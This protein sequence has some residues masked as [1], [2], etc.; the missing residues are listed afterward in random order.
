VKLSSSYHTLESLCVFSLVADNSS[1]A[2]N[3]TTRGREQAEQSLRTDSRLGRIIRILAD[4]ATVVVS[5]TKLA[6]EIDTNRSEVW[7]LVQQLRAFGVEITGHPATGYQLTSVPD[8]LL[9]EA[10]EPLV[11]GT[12]F[13]RDIHHYF[14][15]GSTN[16]EAM[17][18]AADGIA[19][20]SVFIAEEQ[21]AGRG[22]AGHSWA[23]EPS[24]GIYVSLIVR[25]QI[26]PAD[27]LLLS[28]IAGIA[29][30]DAVVDKTGIR[31]DIR[32]PNDLL[33]GEKKFC[34]ILT[35]MNAEVTR[36]RYAVVGIGINVN[37]RIFSNELEPIATSLQL[38]AGQSWSRVALA[39][40][41]LKSF[42]SEY[43][44]LI[45]RDIAEARRSIFERF[46]QRSSYTRGK[47]VHVDENGGY[48]GITAGLDD[49]GFLMI[50]TP[51]GQ[52]TVLSGTVRPVQ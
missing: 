27:A 45:S 49:R 33:L 36:V 24:T 31:P 32:W 6:H 43:R 22:R 16:T 48:D 18:A 28:L 9:P 13:A 5:G 19:E 41:L 46:Q 25:P 51:E 4:N 2:A 35:E 15:V 42:D 8:L 39:A 38:A 12:L 7:R 40:A 3:Q 20:G 1:I 37:Q 11:K 26:A 44:Q 47:R 10:L 23:S 30:F 52:R 21:T 50:E 14:R 29:A 17:Q 34:G